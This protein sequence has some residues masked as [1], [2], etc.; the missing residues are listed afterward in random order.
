MINT[1][2]ILKIKNSVPNKT[3]KLLNVTQSAVNSPNFPSFSQHNLKTSNIHSNFSCNFSN[4]AHNTSNFGHKASYFGHKTSNFGHKTSNFR[5]NASNFARNITNLSCNTSNI[6]F[7]S[8]IC[9]LKPLNYTFCKP[10]VYISATSSTNFTRNYAK[11][12]DKKKEKGKAK[13]QINETQM[14]EL[15]NVENL[16]TQM[17]RAIDVLKDDFTKNLS[18][19]STSGSIES[20][21]VNVDGEEHTLQELAQIVRKNPK[22]VVINMS[23]FPQAI[24]AVLQSLAKSGMNLNPQQEGTTL[25]VPVPKL[26]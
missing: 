24:P 2:H 18:L 12:K 6:A 9:T 10:T 5:Q 15:V 13:V 26:V 22:M 16:K 1:H 8:S 11:G 17:Q 25:Y 21:I 19:R 20:L 23:V 3:A 4:F 14:S 7:N